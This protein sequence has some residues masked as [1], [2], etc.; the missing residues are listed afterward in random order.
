MGERS[1]MQSICYYTG[2]PTWG[3]GGKQR[4]EEGEREKNRVG[5]EERRNKVFERREER[6]E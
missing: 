5:R 3:G 2:M 6:T 4:R 1:E